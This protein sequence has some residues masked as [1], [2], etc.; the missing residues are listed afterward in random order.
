MNLLIRNVRLIDGTGADAIPSVNVVVE[1][2]VISWI[3][4]GNV[5]PSAHPH[6]EDINGEDLTLM[7]GTFDCHEH[8]AGDGGQNGVLMM[9]DDVPEVLLVKAAA[10][11]RRALMTGQTSARDVGSPYGIS[12]T[13]A[14]QVA[15]GSIPGPR[16][17]AAGQWIQA[18][19]TW[20]YSMVHTIESADQMR[21]VVTDQI[22][23]GAGLI[24]VGATGVREDGSDYATLGPEI[25]KL[26]VDLAHGVGL[27]V[28]AHCT[29]FAGATEAVEAGIDSI[30]HCTNIDA[31]TARLMA[32]KGTVA[33]PTMST[34][35]YRLEAAAR[36]NLPK[37]EI[38][39]AEGRRDA[40]RASFRDMLD[41]GVKIAAGTDAGG[42]PVRHGTIVHE[43]EVMI[44]A[45]L[46]TMQAIE[47]ATRIAA[48]IT[49]TLK[50]TG[51]VEVG[52]LAD[53]ILIDGDPLSDIGAMRDVW[54][55]FQGGRR[56][57]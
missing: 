5:T 57:R 13:L 56:V 27:K 15:T 23:Q 11:A 3:G 21:Q 32:Q 10:N 39:L 45:G 41:A 9:N 6:Y 31:A 43:M 50:D 38:D 22:S 35:D 19:T 53:L 17:T 20:P 48:E 30:E 8:F 16:I 54:A 55:V 36:W 18:P 51:T 25:A 1:N 4:E 40:S 42:S 29:G 44:E 24:K 28:A 49:G 2:G 7:P 46:T 47:S 14:R 34:W 52:K 12:I 26:V 37:E 33:V